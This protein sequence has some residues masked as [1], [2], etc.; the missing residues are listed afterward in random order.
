MA[1]QR[2]TFTKALFGDPDTEII[3][4]GTLTVTRGAGVIAAGA[5]G[6]FVVFDAANKG[7]W[8]TFSINQKLS[9][10]LVTAA[11]W[12]VILA[13]DAISR[14]IA[15]AGKSIGEV[16]ASSMISLPKGVTAKTTEGVDEPGWSV[17]AVRGDDEFLLVK[18]GH[19]AQ[20]LKPDK[21]QIT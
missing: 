10:V 21:F 14:G 20:W 11:I 16:G 17:V 18:A 8:K 3:K 5:I 1:S 13:A 19:D 9:F 7:P 6:V 12:G 2:N 4:A 15:A